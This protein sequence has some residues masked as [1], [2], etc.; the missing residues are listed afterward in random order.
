MTCI[1]DWCNMNNGFLTAV[2]SLVGLIISTIA[3]IVSI[4]TARLPYKKKILLSCSTDIGCFADPASGQAS[5]EIVGISV[6]A[7]NVGSRN[8]NITYLGISVKDKS[9]HG[10]QNK[11]TK[12]RDEIT[13]TGMISPTEVKTEFFKKIDLVYALAKL[14]N[15]AR[16]YLYARDSEGREYSK[17]I[18]RANGIVKTLSS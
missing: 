7:T 10:G 1:I 13:G 9:L 14:G 6:N 4:K 12:L 3:V 16:V 17:K 11:M 5:S 8:V 18:G 15:H 2:L